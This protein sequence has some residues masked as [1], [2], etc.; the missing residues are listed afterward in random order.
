MT[1]TN[2][3]VL[4]LVTGV[5]GNLGSSVAAQLISEGRAV[6]GLVLAGDPAASRVPAE[7]DVRVGDVTD[8][9][10]LD[11]FFEAEAGQD[12]VVIHC[13]AVVTVNAGFSQLVHDVNVTGTAN[14]VNAC[15]GHGVRKLVHV[16][17]TGAI[18][19]QPHGTPIAEVSRFEPEAVVGYYGWTKAAA[20]QL[21]LDAVRDRGLDATLVF[22]TGIFGPDDYAYGPVASFILDYCAGKMSAGIEGSFNAVDSRDLATAIVRA[23]DVGGRGE[24]YVLGNE[25]VSMAEM[26]KLLSRL[27][28]TKEV[29]RILPAWA[30]RLL[31]RTSDLVGNVTGRPGKMTSFAVYN[32]TRNNEFD[33]GKARRELGYTTRPFAESIHDTIDWLVREGRIEPKAA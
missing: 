20:S 21:V 24:C 15:L 1:E 8:P 11:G 22:P 25:C 32:L 16:S 6:R 27:T 13:A 3:N 4:F 7:V 5:A 19:E 29:T 18:P 2:P 30:G 28:G 14:I 23:A 26:F 31:G 9:G 12:L 33:S 10:S 17:S